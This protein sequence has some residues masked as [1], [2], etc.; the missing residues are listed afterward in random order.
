MLE[1]LL[2]MHFVIMLWVRTFTFPATQEKPLSVHQEKWVRM[3]HVTENLETRQVTKQQEN[4][5]PYIQTI[6]YFIALQ[7]KTS[8]TCNRMNEFQQRNFAC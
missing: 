5:L 3:L 7:I 8:A 1:Q 6:N 4:K 2:G